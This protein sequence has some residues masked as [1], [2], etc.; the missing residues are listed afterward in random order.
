VAPLLVV[1]GLSKHFSQRH[2]LLGLQRRPIRAVEQV[3]FDLAKGEV[4]GLVGESGSGKSTLG[5]AI[6]RLIEPT[7]G[8][9]RFDGI[10]VTALSKAELRRLRRRMQIVFQD[11]YGSLDPRK[12]VVDLIGDA[13]DIHGL[14]PGRERRDRVQTLLEQVGLA[15]NQLDRYPHEFSGG[16]RQ[17]IG[18]AR[19]LAVGPSFIVADEPVSALDVSIQA[20]IVNLLADLRAELDLAMLFISHDLSIVEHIADRLMVLYLGRVMEVGP[21]RAIYDAPRHPYTEALLSAAPVL[22]PESRRKRIILEGDQPSPVDP[23]S[24]CVFRTRCPYAIAACAA[25]VPPLREVAPGHSKACVRDDV[26]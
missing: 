12:R 4:L 17:R 5:R 13:L 14:A 9:V 8:R 6:L 26:P 25:A 11:P 21:V 16:Q 18:I 19:A 7:S 1:E 24:G 22:H 15:G 2:G 23:P 20:Q 10:E 3:G